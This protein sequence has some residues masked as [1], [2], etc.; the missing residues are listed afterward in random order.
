MEHLV[1]LELKFDQYAYM[2]LSEVHLE[3]HDESIC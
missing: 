1:F 2:M 3:V